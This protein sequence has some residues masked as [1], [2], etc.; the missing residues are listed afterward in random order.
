MQQSWSA[1]CRWCWPVIWFALWLSGPQ[2]CMK[3]VDDRIGGVLVAGRDRR[4]WSR[5]PRR[6]G[7]TEA[8]R[9]RHSLQF[10]V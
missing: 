10:R 4:R 2:D 6:R 1:A 3:V 5:R 7:E 8:P 9:Y